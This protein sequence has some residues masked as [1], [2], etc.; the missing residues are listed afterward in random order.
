MRK[1]KLD[2]RPLKDQLKELGFKPSTIV[3][4]FYKEANTYTEKIFKYEASFDY[5]LVDKDGIIIT[6]KHF[7]DLDGL[8]IFIK[9]NKVT[10]PEKKKFNVILEIEGYDL[11]NIRYGWREYKCLVEKIVVKEPV[12]AVKVKTS[13]TGK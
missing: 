5:E 2:S 13:K 1:S 4:Y 11:E 10:I 6:Q 7:D 12:K 8:L 9:N 3:S